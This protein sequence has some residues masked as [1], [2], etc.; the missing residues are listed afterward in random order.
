[1]VELLRSALGQTG[2]VDVTIDDDTGLPIV[3]VGRPVTADDVRTLDDDDD[4][5]DVR[6][7]RDDAAEDP[8]DERA[9]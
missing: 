7:L 9:T 5:A 1:M 2:E 6:T 4:D 3:R 8:H